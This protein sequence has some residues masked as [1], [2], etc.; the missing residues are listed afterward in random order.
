M[1]SDLLTVAEVKE[2]VTTGLS[3]AALERVIDSQDA[4]IRRMVGQHDPAA[5][6]VYVY[7]GEDPG[8][9]RVWLPR[10]ASAITSVEDRRADMFSEWTV[11]AAASY[12]LADQGRSVEVA[13]RPFEQLVRVTF[14]P[15]SQNAERIQ[16][17]I[18]LVRLE[19]QD[20]GLESERDDT[21]SYSA[22]DKMKARREIIA[23]LKPGYRML[24]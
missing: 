20:S 12:R 9:S 24:A 10:P 14:T 21:Y 5:T 3:G 15:I 22:K 16:A 7:E 1:A 19:T 11:R 4:Y 23:A 13:V 18:D 17:L 8:L 6:M 2:H